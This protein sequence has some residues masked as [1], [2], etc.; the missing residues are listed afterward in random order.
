MGDENGK[1]GAWR[2]DDVDSGSMSSSTQPPFRDQQVAWQKQLVKRI[3][4][5]MASLDFDCCTS[6]NKLDPSL[7]R[8]NLMGASACASP[9]LRLIGSQSTQG[10]PR[11]TTDVPRRS[12]YLRS[13]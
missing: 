9:R 4:S 12:L 13:A 5:D 11:P 10:R 6:Y 1:I 2:F 3:R 8:L 7:R